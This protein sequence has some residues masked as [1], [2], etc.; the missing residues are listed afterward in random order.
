MQ[1]YGQ[2]MKRGSTIH[3]HLRK[4]DELSDQL[5]ALGETVSELNKVA[6]LLKSVQEVYPTLV[7]ALLARGDSELTFMFTKQALLDEEQRR[8]KGNGIHE[9]PKPGDEALKAR[10]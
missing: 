8:S 1:L 7:T 5:K 3:D 2:R 6:I 9:S 4:I 10:A